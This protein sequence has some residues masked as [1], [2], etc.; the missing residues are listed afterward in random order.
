M[1]EKPRLV[2]TRAHT[3]QIKL[4]ATIF[5]VFLLV[6]GLLST[7][8][9]LTFYYFNHLADEQK[10]RFERDGRDATG[11]VL[12]KWKQTG[13]GTATGSGSS[14]STSFGSI[15][16]YLTVS[17]ATLNGVPRESVAIVNS[18][19]LWS[20]IKDGE[21]LD[22]RYLDALPE[23]VI[24]KKDDPSEPMETEEWAILFGSSTVFLMMAAACFWVR[25]RFGHLTPDLSQQ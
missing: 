21:R 19:S 20:S 15:N 5:G 6:M 25:Q 17:Y 3:V 11:Q 12:K 8:F 22:I 18:A 1:V 23:F 24:A 9:A 4:F 10:A 16:Y 13:S 14:R 2:M 7:A